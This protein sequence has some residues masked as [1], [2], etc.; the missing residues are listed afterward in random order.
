MAGTGHDYEVINVA[1]VRAALRPFAAS[2]SYPE[3]R[4][5]FGTRSLLRFV[6]SP[7][8]VIR[9]S[10]QEAEEAIA[11]NVEDE[12][13]RG[14]LMGKLAEGRDLRLFVPEFLDRIGPDFRHIADW[15]ESL[16]KDDPRM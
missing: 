1:R 5:W 8:F 2:V 16:P 11:N 4:A 10:G 7:N 9:V 13:E 3:G 14:I 15:L 12:G 6:T